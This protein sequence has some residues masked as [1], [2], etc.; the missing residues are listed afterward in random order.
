MSES[1]VVTSC[2][3]LS[4]ASGR[5]AYD[6]FAPFYD[7]FTA[8]HDYELWIGGLLELAYEHGLYGSTALD[9]GCGTGKSFLP[10]LG[11]GFSMTACD[12]SQAMLDRATKKSPSVRFHLLDARDLPVLGSFDL[13]TCLDDVVNYQLETGDLIGLL[14]GV[15]RNL[16]PGG[17]LVFDTNTLNGLAGFFRDRFVVGDA[18]RLAVWRG[19]LSDDPSPG[20]VV[21]G[22]L[23]LIARTSDGG[24]SGV[25]TTHRQRHYPQAAIEEAIASVGLELAAAVGQFP[26]V[27]FEPWIDEAAHSKAIYLARRPG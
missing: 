10:L 24:W 9:V 3:A 7:E 14:A 17:V 21:D 13:V 8:H 12:S 22:D 11:R 6:A 27:R 26:D 1:S 15:A 23:A 16:R 19:R 5:A 25:E 20:C 4:L 18:D 2:G